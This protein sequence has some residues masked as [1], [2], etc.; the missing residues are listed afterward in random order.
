M[1]KNESYFLG[2]RVAAWVEIACFFLLCLAIAFFTGTNFNFFSISPHPFW[3]VVILISVQYGTLAGLLAALVAT[4]VYLAGPLPKHNILLEWSEYFFLLAKLP[5]LWFVSALILGELRMKHIRERDR[6]R[7]IAYETEEREKKLAEAYEGLKRIKERLEL[8][9]ASEVPTT[10]MIL[11]AFKKLEECKKDE[12]IPRACELIKILISP[13]KFSIFLLNLNQLEVV[14]TEGWEAKERYAG[15]FA[16]TT[17]LFR[18]IVEKK[19]VVSLTTSDIDSL[20]TEGVL[21]APILASPT[22]KVIGMI[23]IELMSF[24]QVKL[25][26]I[27]TLQFI[28]LRIGKAYERL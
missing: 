23:K 11:E 22:S 10:L 3:I 20:G 18:E 27:E 17:P 19:R 16:S 12:I 14:K 24:H 28:G 9:V 26:T 13:E 4:I 7:V 2:I 1:K 8:R 5:L 6:L 15:S 21:A 25:V